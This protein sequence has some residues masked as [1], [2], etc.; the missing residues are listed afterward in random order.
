MTN[1]ELE[2]FTRLP[3][4]AE[5]SE[6]FW[7]R[8]SESNSRIKVLQTSPLPLGYRALPDIKVASC[9]Q[10]VHLGRNGRSGASARTGSHPAELQATLIR[11]S[12]SNGVAQSG[13]GRVRI[14]VY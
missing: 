11:I 8:G 10:N 12:G 7:R 14:P 1:W 6:F 5:R 2:A 4:R 3:S 13:P 9:T